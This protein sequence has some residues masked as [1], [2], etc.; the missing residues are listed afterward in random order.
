[1]SLSAGRPIPSRPRLLWLAVCLLT[2]SAVAACAPTVRAPPPPPQAPPIVAPPQT[3]APPPP[4]IAVQPLLPG[5]KVPVA[6]LLPLSGPS[7]ALGQGM[8][9]AALMAVYDAGADSVQLMPHDTGAGP[10]SAADA[11]SA[12]IKDGARL[13]IGPL[14][15]GDVEAVK[16]IAQA[17]GVPV[18]AFSTTASL[19]GNGTYLLSFQP[20]QEIARIVAYAHAKGASRFAILAPRTPYGDLAITAMQDAV[21]ANQS[22][23]GKTGGYDPSIDGLNDA[24]RQFARQ[25]IGY[26]ALL[27]PDGGTRLMALAPYLAFY[28]IDPDKIHYL[29]TGLW[30]DASLGTE[31]TLIHGWYAA[32]D[33]QGRAGFERR[34]QEAEGHAPPRLATLAYDATALAAV[35]AKNP[36][37]PDFSPASLTNP[38]GFVGLDGVFRLHEDGLIERQLAVLEVERNGPRVIDPAP[39]SFIALTQ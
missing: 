38:S 11:A 6:L 22:E 20:R 9:D 14:L 13:I 17:A 2:V 31:G 32:P 36:A 8:L 10:Q 21:T 39:Q 33:P 23:L 25:G 5:A 30:D 16:P 18:L 29:G 15:A 12:A 3:Q 26:Q 1:M 27:L 24:A 35:L 34:F 28:H 19:A 4:P 7:A 37:G